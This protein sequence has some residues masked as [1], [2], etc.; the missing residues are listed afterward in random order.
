MAA[1]A[2]ALSG[3]S[4]SS[5]EK[6]TATAAKTE[7]AAESK[8]AESTAP[9]TTAVETTSE[10]EPEDKGGFKV[11]GTK[12]LDANGNEFVMRGI[13][14]AHSWYKD[15]DGVSLKAISEAGCAHSVR[16]RTEIFRRCGIYA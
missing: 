8:E 13:N 9:E 5:S 15:Q 3:C 11:E 6:E 10:A 12:L 4:G 16:K 14:E 7:T 2:I 1:G